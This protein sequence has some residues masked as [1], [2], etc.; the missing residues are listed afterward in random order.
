MGAGRC[1]ESDRAGAAKGWQARRSVLGIAGWL[2]PGTVLAIM[3]EC[4][5]CM[6]AYIAIGTGLALPV[7]TAASMRT[8]LVASCA[9]SLAYLVARR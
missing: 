2:V 1:C 3:P 5:M 8:T 6:A 9:A 4:P 7:P